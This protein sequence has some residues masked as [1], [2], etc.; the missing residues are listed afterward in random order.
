MRRHC[1]EEDIHIA[2]K[3]M[4]TRSVSLATGEPQTKT[5]MKHHYTPISMTIIISSVDTKCW[6]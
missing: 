2:N 5:T 1:G 6:C 4:E 3:H